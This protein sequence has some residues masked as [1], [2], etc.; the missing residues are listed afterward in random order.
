MYEIRQI[1][2]PESEP[3]SNAILCGSS[4][5]IVL[6]GQANEIGEFGYL[7]ISSAI[8]QTIDVNFKP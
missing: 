5:K 3:R 1:P 6:H 8:Q 7:Q 4:E 2:R